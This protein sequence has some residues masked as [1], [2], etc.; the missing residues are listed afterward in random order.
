MFL[1][2][3]NL[4]LRVTTGRCEY[5]CG[6]SRHQ[7]VS[8]LASQL[9]LGNTIQGRNHRPGTGVEGDTH[10]YACSFGPFFFD[11]EQICELKPERVHLGMPQSLTALTKERTHLLFVAYNTGLKNT[12]CVLSDTLS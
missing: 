12:Q 10:K 11:L 6:T 3:L 9:S 5:I 8:W 1:P 4:H 7:E 2:E